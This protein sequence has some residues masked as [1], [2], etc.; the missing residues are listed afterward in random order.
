MFNVNHIAISVVDS[1]RSIDFYKKFGFENYKS[2]EADDSSIKI[3]MLR[4]N[5]VVL[6]IF[7]YKDYKNLP[8]TAKS[9]ATDLPIVGVKHLALG[10]T[11]IEIG[12][13]FVIKNELCSNIEIKVGRLGKP[14][15]FIT[16]PDGIQIEIIEE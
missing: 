7:C 9:T 11:D 2:W 4:L 13:K 6:E 3:D 14:Y 12:K 8:E 16:D 1:K 5:N 15:F 10:V